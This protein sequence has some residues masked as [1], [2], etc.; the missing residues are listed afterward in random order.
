M[1]GVGRL[2]TE[3]GGLRAVAEYREKKELHLAAGRG[4]VP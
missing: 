2:V 3:H 1:R 4:L